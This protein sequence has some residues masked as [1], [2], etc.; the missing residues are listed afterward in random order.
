MNPVHVAQCR[1]EGAREWIVGSRLQLPEHEP[2]FT[3]DLGRRERRL[4]HD[5]GEKR[6]QRLPLARDGRAPQLGRLHFAGGLERATKLFDRLDDRQRRT[7]LRPA[8]ENALHKVRDPGRGLA[9]EERAGPYL[10]RRRH[11]A[12]AW[13]L[14][15]QHRH[16]V[17]QHAAS[18]RH[19]GG[20]R[21]HEDEDEQRKREPAQRRL[22]GGTSARRV[23]R[24][25][26]R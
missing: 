16:P 21:R 5:F 15:D 17:R 25:G 19:L 14:T 8:H 10:Q 18:N 12:D 26:S 6:E 23:Y 7:L 9:F 4:E 24:S 11:D 2:P 22:R 1:V 3:L 13:V 20:G